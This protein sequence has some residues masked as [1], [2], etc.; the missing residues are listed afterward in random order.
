MREDNQLPMRFTGTGGEYFRI[1]IVNIA[2]TII[3]LGIYSPWAK[4]RSK[5]WF[6]GHTFLDQQ[7]FS[8]HATPMQ[9]LKGR[10]MAVAYIVTYFIVA[11]FSPLLSIIMMIIGFLTIPW[12]IVKSLR[13]NA[14]NSSYRGIRFGFSGSVSDSYMNFFIFPILIMILTLGLGMPYIIYL[15]TKFIVGHYQYGQTDN[16]FKSTS[17]PFW[18]TYGTALISLVILT[19]L[20]VFSLSSAWKSGAL[21]SGEFFETAQYLLPII[22]LSYYLLIIFLGAFIKARIANITYNQSQLEEVSFVSNQSA[23]GVTWIYGSNLILM[24]LT[25]GLFT[26]WAQVRLAQYRA[27]HLRIKTSKNLEDFVASNH[28]AISASGDELAEVLDM[29]FGLA[30]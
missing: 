6:Y 4:V 10:L 27:D 17:G 2:L 7:A 16:Q 12:I 23:W 20:L 3:T 26:P 19:S 29:D 22:S 14:Q 28:Q 11:Q 1:W 18:R 25:L 9:I 8:Y 13:F 24:A 5:R 15:Q 21:L 30:G